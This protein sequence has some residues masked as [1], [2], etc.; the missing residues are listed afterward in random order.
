MLC[1]AY[2]DT[3]QIADNG[4]NDGDGVRSLSLAGVALNVG[5]NPIPLPSHPQPPPPT[6]MTAGLASQ[7]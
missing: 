3:L 1:W 4:H 2:L 7:F 6:G 5:L